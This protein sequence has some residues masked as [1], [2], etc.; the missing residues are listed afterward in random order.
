MQFS[1]GINPRNPMTISTDVDSL[2]GLD[3]LTPTDPAA[4]TQEQVQSQGIRIFF[5]FIFFYFFHKIM[6]MYQS[7]LWRQHCS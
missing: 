7:K 2:G 4:A 5:P 1:I 6:L 3:A